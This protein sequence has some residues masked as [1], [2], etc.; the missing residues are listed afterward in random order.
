[1]YLKSRIVALALASVIVFL[2]TCR[3]SLVSRGQ[4]NATV[5]AAF[6]ALRREA[7]AAL[8]ATMFVMPQ[9]S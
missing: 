7:C 1:V 4:R 8:V 6:H 9:T 5:F 3:F 2:Q